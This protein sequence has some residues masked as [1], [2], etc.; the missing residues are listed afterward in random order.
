MSYQIQTFENVE[1]AAKALNVNDKSR[2]YGGG[3]IL[4][5]HINE[6]DQSFNTIINL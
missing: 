5:R 6:G 2:F 1:D 3:T 4:M